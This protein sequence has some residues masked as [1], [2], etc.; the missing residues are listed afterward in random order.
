MDAVRKGAAATAVCEFHREFV[1]H[2]YIVINNSQLVHQLH[3]TS[4]ELSMHDIRDTFVLVCW[5]YLLSSLNGSCRV[6]T[7]CSGS[8]AKFLVTDSISDM[9]N[10]GF[11]TY[12]HVPVKPEPLLLHETAGGGRSLRQRCPPAALSSSGNPSAH[13]CRTPTHCWRE[14]ITT[15]RSHRIMPPSSFEHIDPLMQWKYGKIL[16]CIFYGSVP[17]VA[18]YHHVPGS[19]LTQCGLGWGL[20][21]YQVTSWSILPFGHNRH[22]P[23]IGGWSW[24]SI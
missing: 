13:G 18:L 20:P 5:L 19:H 11:S 9:G 21:P 14:D 10:P 12:C 3:T 15:Q 24:V 1:V 23:K 4:Q 16:L 17:Q 7:M 8:T 2:S 22:G 6:D